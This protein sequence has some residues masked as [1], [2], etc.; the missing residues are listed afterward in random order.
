MDETQTDRMKCFIE[1]VSLAR[2]S[3]TI[4]NDIQRQMEA[5]VSTTDPSVMTRMETLREKLKDSGCVQN[6][7]KTESLQEIETAVA[8]LKESNMSEAS[9][10]VAYFVDSLLS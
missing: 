3:I 8:K 10:S 1:G 6:E 2:E 4:Q 5:G 7:L 9:K